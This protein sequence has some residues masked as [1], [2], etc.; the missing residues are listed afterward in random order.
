MI[1]RAARRHPVLAGVASLGLAAAVGPLLVPVPPLLDTVPLDALADPDSR[2]LDYRGLRVHYKQ[3]GQG[4]PV[5]VLLHGFGA[6]VFTWRDVLPALAWRGTA[7]AFDRPAFGLTERP[8]IWHGPNPYGVDFQMELTL[9]L[10]DRAGARRGILIG[11]SAGGS[12]ALLTAARRPDRVCALILVDPAVYVGGGA[13]AWLRP[14]LATPQMRRLGPLLLRPLARRADGVLARA[15]HEPAGI[16]AEVRAGYARPLR[17]P[18]WDRALWAMTLATRYPR[19][20]ALAARLAVPTLVIT[21]DDDRIVPTAQSVRLAGTIP[22]AQLRVLPGCGHL[23]QEE[24]PDAFLAA[25][26]SFVDGL[27]PAR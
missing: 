4:R 9:A 10:L 18:H 8:R 26:E 6:S 23:P 14:L 3:A 1:V 5:F 7:V 13:P 16:T 11:N 12:L 19:L 27:G 2:F 17:A 24:C 15:W 25:V 21:G 22:G 20:P